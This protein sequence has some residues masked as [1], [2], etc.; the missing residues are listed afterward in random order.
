MGGSL[1]E[2]AIRTTLDDAWKRCENQKVRNNIIMLPR[3]H[4][5]VYSNRI[6]QFRN[7]A[8]TERRLLK[9]FFRPI[10]TPGLCSLNIVIVSFQRCAS[11]LSLPVLIP[12]RGTSLA[13]NQFFFI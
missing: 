2:D 11:A 6:N 3:R 9:A 5:T 7:M 8:V 13:I 1:R 12:T 10:V 4:P